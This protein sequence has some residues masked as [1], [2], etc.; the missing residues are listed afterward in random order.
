MRQTIAARSA[1]RGVDIAGVVPRSGN[2]ATSGNRRCLRER[3]VICSP[4][5]LVEVTRPLSQL[6]GLDPDNTADMEHVSTAVN[7][8]QRSGSLL[9]DDSVKIVKVAMSAD[10]AYAPTEYDQQFVVSRFQLRAC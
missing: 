4:R 6:G 8:D 7:R 2:A 10:V 3:E 9:L 5:I 1:L